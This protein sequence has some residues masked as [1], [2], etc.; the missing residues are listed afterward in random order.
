MA[1]NKI[2]D[3]DDEEDNNKSKI[4]YFEKATILYKNIIQGE[5]IKRFEFT[6]DEKDALN[7]ISEFL[8][9]SLNEIK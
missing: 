7:F 9:K 5:R 6:Q 3:D 2:I 4:E 1:K 8:D